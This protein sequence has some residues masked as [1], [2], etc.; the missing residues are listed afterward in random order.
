M[1]EIAPDE[2]KAHLSALVERVEQTGDE[3]VITGRGGPAARLVP[4]DDE[5]P[6]ESALALLLAARADSTPGPGTLRELIDE[7][8]GR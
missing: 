1:S 4:I 8:R 7:E 5:S 6:F 2:A 3:I